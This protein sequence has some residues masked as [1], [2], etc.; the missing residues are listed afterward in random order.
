MVKVLTLILSGRGFCFRLSMAWVNLR[1][2]LSKF[3]STP[4][5]FNCTDPRAWSLLSFCSKTTV[6]TVH[7][8]KIMWQRAKPVT[9]DNTTI[10][11]RDLSICSRMLY[12]WAIYTPLHTT[13]PAVHHCPSYVASINIHI[14]H[15]TITSLNRCL[16]VRGA[17]KRRGHIDL[18]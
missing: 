14:H 10:W 4:S 17:K 7:T 9:G 2:G 16:H 13:L 15:H 12:Q 1:R 11:T 3:S 8:H 18:N 6:P 5:T